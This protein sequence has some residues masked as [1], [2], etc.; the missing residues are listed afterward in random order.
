MD[1][2]NVENLP[3]VR[4]TLVAWVDLE[5]Q[6]GGVAEE[7]PCVPLADL[8]DIQS[9]SCFLCLALRVC[10]I[11]IGP[12]ANL[13]RNLCP[14]T[15]SRC[16]A[17]RAPLLEDAAVQTENCH[18]MHTRMGTTDRSQSQKI[19]PYAYVTVWATT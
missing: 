10:T 1:C 19:A 15:I 13:H 8:D 17:S 18:P 9:F 11:K 14:P 16:P 6:W 3:A 7:S 5:Y 4:R 12:N 2:E